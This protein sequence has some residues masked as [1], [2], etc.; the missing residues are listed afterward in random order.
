LRG[1]REERGK[2]SVVGRER[3]ITSPA[4]IRVHQEELTGG[5]GRREKVIPGMATGEVKRGE[6]RKRGDPPGDGYRR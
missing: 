5:G 4:D 6:G 3:R 2:V 1:A